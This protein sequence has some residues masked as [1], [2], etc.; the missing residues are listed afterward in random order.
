MPLVR[1]KSVK[2]KASRANAVHGGPDGCLIATH[3]GRSAQ[4]FS[5]PG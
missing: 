2:E 3:H 4:L 1:K 5:H